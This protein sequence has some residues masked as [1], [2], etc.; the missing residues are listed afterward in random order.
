[1]TEATRRITKFNFDD[2][3]AH[4]ALVD[5]PANLQEVLVMKSDEKVEPLIEEHDNLNKEAFMPDT[6]VED[7]N[8]LDGNLAL[9]IQ[10]Q[11]AKATAKATLEASVL[12][13]KA[14]EESLIAIEKAEAQVVEIEKARDVELMK[15]FIRKAI[16]LAAF[17]VEDTT[18][19]AKSLMAVH[20]LGKDGAVIIDALE[21]AASMHTETLSFDELGIT[22]AAE[23]P[24]ETGLRKALRTQ[25]NK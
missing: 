8:G 20:A 9:E 17:G 4:V 2:D 16:K 14:Q 19:F 15:G 18:G 11:I 23:V 3:G 22:L 10:E 24:E 25:L 7:K 1:M 6:K 5:K 12:I 21:K 13:K